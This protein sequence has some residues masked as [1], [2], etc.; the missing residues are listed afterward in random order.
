MSLLRDKLDN[1]YYWL[2]EWY[3]K[4]EYARLAAI[5]FIN[6]LLFTLTYLISRSICTWIM[7]LYGTFFDIPFKIRYA[8]IRFFEE[9]MWTNNEVLLTYGTPRF[10]MFLLGLVCLLILQVGNLRRTYWGWFLRWMAVN[11]LSLFFS[12]MLVGYFFKT[13]F[14]YFGTYLF[15]PLQGV[16]MIGAFTTVF[17][18]VFFALFRP[19]LKEFWYYF[20]PVLGMVLFALINTVMFKIFFQHYMYKMALENLLLAVPMM[21]LYSR[22]AHTGMHYS[23]DEVYK[24]TILTGVLLLLVWGYILW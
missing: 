10:V 14:A 18:I 16:G 3:W 19:L 15:I 2:Q 12:G 13:E 5:Y 7:G 24:I 11:S 9:R 8:N 17:S 21:G 23:Y 6:Y 20:N 4:S 1:V 22:N